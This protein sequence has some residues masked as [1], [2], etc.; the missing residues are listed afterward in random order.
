MTKEQL[1]EKA[2]QAQYNAYAPYSRFNVGA[3]VLGEN[4]NVYLGGNIENASYGL[5]VCAER[6]AVFGMINA[7]CKKF[8]ALAV[9]GGNDGDGAPCCACRQVLTE[10]CRDLDVP[11][12]IS[13]PSGT[14][15]EHS[16]REIAPLPFMSFEPNAD[17]EK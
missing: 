8:V 4:G 17:Y 2:W 5:T 9:V 3:A 15:Y 14:I 11:I 10:F 13:G 1:I 12:Y 6:T 16:L 7:G